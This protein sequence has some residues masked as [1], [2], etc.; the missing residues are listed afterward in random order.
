MVEEPNEEFTSRH[1]LEWKFLLLDHRFSHLLIISLSMFVT[2][3]F[4]FIEIHVCSS[5]TEHLLSLAIC[6]LRCW[7]RQAMTI[8]T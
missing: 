6:P 5:V 1:S 8:I 7:E 3:S 4:P 2:S